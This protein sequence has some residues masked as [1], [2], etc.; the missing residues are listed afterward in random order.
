MPREKTL[1]RGMPH[2]SLADDRKAAVAFEF[3]MNMDM[4]FKLMLDDP[5]EVFYFEASF[6]ARNDSEGPPKKLLVRRR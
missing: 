1:A 2:P 6:V 3:D 5:T 4:D